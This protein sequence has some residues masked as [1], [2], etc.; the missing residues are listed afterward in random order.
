MKT[1]ILIGLI[2]SLSLSTSA[3][4]SSYKVTKVHD[5]DTITVVNTTNSPAII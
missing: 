5:G 4:A 3:V 2:T 1:S